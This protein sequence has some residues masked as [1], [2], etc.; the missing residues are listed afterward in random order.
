MVACCSDG[1]Q[2][3]RLADAEDMSSKKAAKRS[4]KKANK[5]E[6]KVAA[7][8]AKLAVAASNGD[9]SAIDGLLDSG[10]GL[11]INALTDAKNSKDGTFQTTALSRAITA[12]FTGSDRPGDLVAAVRLQRL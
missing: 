3:S 10:G 1:S 5:A 11:D 2:P 6:A 4:K 9:C 8:A 7:R 12:S